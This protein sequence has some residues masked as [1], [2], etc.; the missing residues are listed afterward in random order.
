MNIVF[1]INIHSLPSAGSVM[2]KAYKPTIRAMYTDPDQFAEIKRSILAEFNGCN[3][4]ELSAKYHF[5]R[6]YI[7]QLITRSQ[8]DA[9]D[10]P[11]DRSLRGL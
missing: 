10:D 7:E 4:D 11:R 1:N 9:T 5:T 2:R 6:R 3:H 8:T